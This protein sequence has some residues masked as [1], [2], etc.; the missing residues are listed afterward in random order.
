MRLLLSKEK[1]KSDKSKEFQP[2][3]SYLSNT[4]AG[5]SSLNL[6]AYFN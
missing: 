4:E 3:G 5:L 6:K 1:H 2:A